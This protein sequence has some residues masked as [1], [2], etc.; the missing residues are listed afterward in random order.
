M[1][2]GSGP[3][4]AGDR[5]AK[6]LAFA[7]GCVALRSERL[8][9]LRFLPLIDFGPTIRGFSEPRH[10]KHRC[11]LEMRHSSSQN[12]ALRESHSRCQRLRQ[13]YLWRYQRPRR[14]RPERRQEAQSSFFVAHEPSWFHPRPLKYDVVP[15]TVSQTSL[16]RY[17]C[18]VSGPKR[19]PTPRPMD[20]G[21]RGFLAAKLQENPALCRALS[22]KRI[23]PAAWR[24]GQLF[25][26]PRVRWTP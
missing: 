9:G 17:A 15:E 4:S 12:P 7:P 25:G 5:A 2:P 26:L 23:V 19:T 16:R 3:L 24:S 11:L 10:A 22:A 1:Q 14:D 18:N 8:S 21:L 6:L 13:G 20:R